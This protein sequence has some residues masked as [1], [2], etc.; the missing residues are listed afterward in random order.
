MSAPETIPPKSFGEELEI[1]LAALWEAFR[2]EP[3]LP[4][5]LDLRDAAGDASTRT[6]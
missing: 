4:R 5:L 6:E 2:A 1:R 3:T